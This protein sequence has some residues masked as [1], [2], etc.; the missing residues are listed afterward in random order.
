MTVDG[1][2]VTIWDVGGCD[3]IRPLWR[4]YFQVDELYPVPP[5]TT[6]LREIGMREFEDVKPLILCRRRR[7]D[8]M[9][10]SDSCLGPLTL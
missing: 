8:W 7:L 9:T 1:T 3:K 10:V 4:H 2:E 6:R 5:K